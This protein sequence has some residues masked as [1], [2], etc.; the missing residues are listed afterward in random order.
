[1]CTNHTQ[2]HTKEHA[3]MN[4]GLGKQE[5]ETWNFKVLNTQAANLE[6]DIDKRVVCKIQDLSTDKG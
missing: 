6:Q 4:E 5:F 1:M 3:N 2:S